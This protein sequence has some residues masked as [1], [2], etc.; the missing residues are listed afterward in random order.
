MGCRVQLRCPVGDDGSR[1]AGGR[2]GSLRIQ[3]RW[4]Q[5]LLAHAACAGRGPK[6]M[7][8][9]LPGQGKAPYSLPPLGL[10]T[11]PVPVAHATKHTT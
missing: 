3:I 6:H 2:V 1:S 10:L 8:A 11:Q 7:H 9:Q 4:G 5:R